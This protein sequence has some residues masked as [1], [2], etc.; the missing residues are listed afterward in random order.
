[1]PLLNPCVSAVL[2][3]YSSQATYL[4]KVEEWGEKNYLQPEVLSYSSL[5]SL[6]FTQT[7]QLNWLLVIAGYVL[8]T[9][10]KPPMGI[11]LVPR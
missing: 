9:F 6:L 1:M 4:L 2:E 7:Q 3:L 5:M 10:P 11:N 8:T